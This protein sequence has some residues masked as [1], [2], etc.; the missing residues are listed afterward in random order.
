MFTPI[1]YLLFCLVT[2]HFQARLRLHPLPFTFTSTYTVTFT[3]C[4]PDF[5]Y[6]STFY[7]HLRS[8]LYFLYGIVSCSS[9][10]HHP[11]HSSLPPFIPSTF[12]LHLHLPPPPP[13]H[14]PSTFLITSCK[15][16]VSLQTPYLLYKM[17]IN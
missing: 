15:T 9:A 11:F 17:G 2:P 12:H 5:I 3:F 14:L 4:S 1:I 13:Y 6:S 16:H 8:H 7:L 10:F